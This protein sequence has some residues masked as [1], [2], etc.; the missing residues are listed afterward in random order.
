MAWVTTHEVFERIKQRGD[1]RSDL[2]IMLTDLASCLSSQSL[3]PADS[4]SG[5]KGITTAL[6][7]QCPPPVAGSKKGAVYA[8]WRDNLLYRN[9]GGLVDVNGSSCNAVLIF[10]GERT[11]TQSRSTLVDQTN[12]ANYL[13]AANLTSFTAGG[14]PYAGHTG[15]NTACP[16]PNQGL[17]CSQD[18]PAC[19]TSTTI[20]PDV[21]FEEDIDTFIPA[22]SSSGSQITV[23]PDGSATLFIT[24]ASN[25]SGC[26]WFPSASVAYN[27]TMRLSFKFRFRDIEGSTT[28]SSYGD[29]FTF[30]IL[31]GNANVAHADGMCGRANQT[32]Y[33]GADGGG[34]APLPLPTPNLA[35]EYD[36]F[37]NLSYQD[38][39]PANK[40]HIAILTGALGHGG[41]SFAT[42]CNGTEAGCYPV[43]APNWL[44]DNMV[45]QTRVE[46]VSGCTDSTCTTCGASGTYALI[47]AWVDCTDCNTLGANFADAPGI[48]PCTP[49][50]SWLNSTANTVKF[51]FTSGESSGVRQTIDLSDF[52]IK[53][54]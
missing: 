38:P 42:P 7:S 24:G 4:G 45:H 18:V 3:L 43:A 47:K 9:A 41:S 31:P 54:Q 36:S 2:D 1:F 14:S 8:N 48:Q 22:G 11:A 27:K 53:F 33:S 20:P 15:F 50:G 40:N 5:S 19:I 35:I 23:N 26:F 21:S 39:A 51:G 28:S 30:T 37:Y 25:K 10:A 13:E 44:E 49:V 12:P 29:G 46:V 17:L 6:E 52:A 32:G 16:A 34:H